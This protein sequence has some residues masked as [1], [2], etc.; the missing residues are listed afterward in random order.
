MPRFLCLLVLI[1][2]CGEAE[3]PATLS[4]ARSD[5]PDYVTVDHILIGVRSPRMPDGFEAKKARTIAYDLLARLEE[6]ESW[7]ALKR[8]HSADP[9]PGGPYKMVNSNVRRA[10][11][12]DVIPRG[13]MVRAFGDVGFALQVGALGM[14]DYHPDKSPFGYHIIKRIQ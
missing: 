6:G 8:S 1:I 13:G 10:A 9:P 11:T 7:D 3:P 12:A 4:G 14:A 2:A 5:E